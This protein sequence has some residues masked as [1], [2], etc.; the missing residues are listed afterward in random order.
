MLAIGS[1]FGLQTIEC[2]TLVVQK[3]DSAIY[4]IN[5]NPLDNYYQHS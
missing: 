3:V 5:Q 1:Y 4:P 2:M